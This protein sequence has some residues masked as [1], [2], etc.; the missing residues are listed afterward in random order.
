MH[1]VSSPTWHR[2]LHHVAADIWSFDVHCCRPHPCRASILS[3]LHCRISLERQVV[4]VAGGGRHAFAMAMKIEMHVLS[5][6]RHLG[7]LSLTNDTSHVAV[8]HVEGA[9]ESEDDAGRTESA[10]LI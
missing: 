1:P 5:Y 3:T 10:T 9:D 7:P 2:R 6:P 4:W 8:G